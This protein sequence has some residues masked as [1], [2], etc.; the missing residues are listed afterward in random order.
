MQ[1]YQDCKNA[2]RQNDQAAKLNVRMETSSSQEASASNPP[3]E[4]SRKIA[5]RPQRVARCTP[6]GICIL[7]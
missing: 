7:G 1:S 3:F 6:N 4:G 5:R 2:K